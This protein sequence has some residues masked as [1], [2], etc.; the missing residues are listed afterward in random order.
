MNRMMIVLAALML[1]T[2]CFAQQDGLEISPLGARGT[3]VRVV[4][5][6]HYV[7]FPVQESASDIGIKVMVD[8]EL[9]RTINVKLA[10]DSIDYYV[11][12]DM[13]GYK[14]KSV[15]F[16]I[17][18]NMP[19]AG[20]PQ[21][22]R[23]PQPP[24]AKPMTDK[25][26][27]SDTFDVRNREA[28]RPVYHFTPAYGWMNDPNGMVYKDGEWHLFYQYNPY[29]SVW[30]NMHWGHAVSRDL[31]H[32][33]HLPVALAPD[34]IGTIFSG[35]AVVDHKNTA[36]FGPGAIVAIY[37]SSGDAQIQ[38]IAYS[39]D[40]GRTFQ[41][42]PGNPVL[43]SDQGNFRDPKVFWHEGRQRWIMILAVGREV[44]FYSSAN[45]KEWQYESSFGSEYG[46]HDGVF[47]CPD[48]LELPVE[49]TNEKK[50]LVIVNINPGGPSG[51]SAT[52][53]FVGDFDGYRFSC[54][55]APETTKW[56]DW[57]KDHYATVSFADAPG[58]RSV[59]LAWMSNWQYAGVVPT[60]QFRSANSIPRDLSLYKKGSE[61]YVKVDPSPEMAAL[62]K[63]P[64]KK[65][66]GNVSGQKELR[67]ILPEI[68]EMEVAFTPKTAKV[69][70]M[71]FSND[72]G[73]KVVMTYD[74]NQLKFIM[75]RTQSGICDFSADYPVAS[76]APIEKNKQYGLR[77][78]VDKCSIEAFDAQGRMVMTNLVFPTEPYRHVRF[79]TETGTVRVNSVTIFPQE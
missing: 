49:G 79:F 47:E 7:L 23:R 48:I 32:W 9:E 61:H 54:E 51:G 63:A 41:K 62:R 38:S 68:F 67:G 33:E 8:T 29:A 66:V 10:T 73:E 44:R 6:K 4:S 24:V 31:V 76:P 77:L 19:R 20:A 37:T 18:Q 21:Q 46:N 59:V 71:E 25:I 69:F 45:L 13:S 11:P 5:P 56:M 17:R 72:K 16:V 50:W 74:L 39:T 42:Y 53:Y 3:M 35:S 64:V 15:Y 60:L 52:Q 43:T 14:G 40:N 34:G 2:L 55:S 1:G 22:G 30:G 78:F 12:F 36:G 26:L 70:S 58:G 27:S 57:G 75:D 28:Y 65:S